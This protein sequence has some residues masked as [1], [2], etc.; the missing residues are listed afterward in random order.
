MPTITFT[1]AHPDPMNPDQLAD[2]IARQFSLTTNP[3][4]DVDPLE[5]R[6]TH[7]Q[8]SENQR[9]QVQAIIDAYVLDPVWQ[10]GIAA[11]LAEKAQ[12]ALTTNSAY[13]AHAA[14]P[15]GTLTAAQLSVIVR[16]LSDQVDTLTKECTALIRLAT[17]LLDSTSGT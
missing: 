2:L 4:V 7:P 5:I 13:L 14:I 3:K 1:G 12:A 11:V 17:S 8:A 16:T 15:G 6:V 10:G 9:T